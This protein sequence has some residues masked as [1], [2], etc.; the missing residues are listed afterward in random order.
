METITG[1]RIFVRVVEAGSFSE[2]GRQLGLAP[3][4]VSRQIN[5]LE[6]SLGAQLFQRTT[7][8]LSLT[9][10]GELYYER[11]T[12]IVTEID[13]AKLALYQLDGTLTGILHLNVCLILKADVQV[14]VATTT[15]ESTS[16]GKAFVG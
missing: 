16:T 11:A 3:S 14:V 1:L 5:E 12:S 7:R 6:D 10:A 2:A 4:S 13:E 15:A 8:K 9:E